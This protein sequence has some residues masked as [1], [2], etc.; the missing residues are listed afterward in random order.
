MPSLLKQW[1]SS[2]FYDGSRMQ[3]CRQSLDEA[4]ESK[5]VSVF[6]ASFVVHS[7]I[8][9]FCPIDD[10]SVAS[11]SE[12]RSLAAT[13]PLWCTFVVRAVE[14]IHTAARPATSFPI[15]KSPG[16]LVHPYTP[17][18]NIT[19]ALAKYDAHSAQV[20]LP[21]DTRAYSRP[22]TLSGCQVCMHVGC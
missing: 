13:S 4:N 14:N 1:D 17:K 8:P 18:T 5:T 19:S 10:E 7:L 15:F 22:T 9:F 2:C 16:L 11:T 3:V 12:L 20:P 6:H 21:F